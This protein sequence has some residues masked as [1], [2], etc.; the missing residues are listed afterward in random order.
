MG[1]IW[2]EGQT[3]PV[4][5]YR[6]CAQGTLDESILAR[7]DDKGQLSA[8]V[9][10]QCSL[11]P[12]PLNV[13][14]I[15]AAGVGV[16]GRVVTGAQ[17]GE[18]TEKE[19]E[20][21]Y[22]LEASSVDSEQLENILSSLPASASSTDHSSSLYGSRI[23]PRVELRPRFQ[24]ASIGTLVFPRSECRARDEAIDGD[25]YF[26]RSC[27]DTEIVPSSSALIADDKVL[28]N[29]FRADNE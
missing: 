9:D 13:N 17:G 23:S 25:V 24:V 26:G 4:F 8:V 18:D 29:C 1:R 5:V 16:R 28:C 2:R 11:F 22:N 14:A 3:K 15:D 10:A 19:K 7:Q 21:R 6:L 20:E 27:D 12:T